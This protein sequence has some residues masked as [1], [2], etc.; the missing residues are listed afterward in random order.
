MTVAEYKRSRSISQ[1]KS[2]TRCPEAFRIERLHRKEIPER[3]GVWTAL[4]VAVHE[5]SLFWEMSDRTED[6]SVAFETYFDAYIEDAREKQPD[7]SLWMVPPGSKDVEKSIKTYRERGLTRDIPN[8]KAFCEGTEEEP[9]EWEIYKFDDG[10]KAL[11]LEFE[12]DF[13][14]LVVKGAVDAVHYWPERDVA[15]LTDWKSGNL[16]KWD[17]RQLGAYSYALREQY[18]IEIKH[19][20]YFFTKTNQT[21]D[22]FDLTRY[23]KTYLGDLF[24][25]LDTIVNEGLFLPSPGD[26]CGI[27]AVKPYCRELGSKQLPEKE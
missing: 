21:S 10:S 23:D 1:L 9:V 18:G 15:T 8:L 2:L 12:I 5:A 16:E 25:S 26:V 17:A 14:G 24:R 20:R 11:E 19:G 6:L 4:G 3:P 7:L 22:W 27:C 13:D